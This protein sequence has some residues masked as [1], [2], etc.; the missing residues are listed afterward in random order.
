MKVI[1]T[2]MKLFLDSLFFPVIKVSIP[3]NTV[4]ITIALY[5]LEIK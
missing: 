3:P 1:H 4:M 5:C 2:L